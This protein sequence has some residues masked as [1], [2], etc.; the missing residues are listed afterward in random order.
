M[1]TFFPTEEGKDLP[2]GG[3]FTSFE[4]HV[5]SLLS[6]SQKEW[7]RVSKLLLEAGKW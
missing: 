4:Q 6:G 3:N 1:P 2:N 5:P 7:E